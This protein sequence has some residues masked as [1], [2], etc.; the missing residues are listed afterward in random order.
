MQGSEPV[1]LGTDSDGSDGWKL[2]VDTSKYDS[3]I[4][5]MGALLSH[6]SSQAQAR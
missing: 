6:H 4:Y 3:G 1:N 5:K 2:L